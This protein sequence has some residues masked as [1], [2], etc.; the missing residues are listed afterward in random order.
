MSLCRDPGSEEVP[1]RPAPTAGGPRVDEGGWQRRRMGRGGAGGGERG[2]APGGGRPTHLPL[3]PMQ[4]GRPLIWQSMCRKPVRL[5]LGCSVQ[6]CGAPGWVGLCRRAPPAPLPRPLSA[7]I[8]TGHLVMSSGQMWGPLEAGSSQVLG[9]EVGG[10]KMRGCGTPC[11]PHPPAN[12]P[13]GGTDNTVLSPISPAAQP[14]ATLALHLGSWWHTAPD[15]RFR[16][17]SDLSRS[18]LSR[19]GPVSSCHLTKVAKVSWRTEVGWS[20]Q[21]RT[22]PTEAVGGPQGE[23]SSPVSQSPGPSLRP[24]PRRPRGSASSLRGDPPPRLG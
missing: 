11:L 5:L 13:V 7:R 4:Q 6:I 12:V 23:G 17:R 21:D 24:G 19:G 15:V 9:A 22:I 3:V 16:S 10:A 20:C 18:D 8:L 14:R 2:G 1:L